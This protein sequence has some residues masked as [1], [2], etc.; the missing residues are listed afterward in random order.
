MATET[1]FTPGSGRRTWPSRVAPWGPESAAA[2]DRGNWRKKDWA[3]FGGGATTSG[4][5]TGHPRRMPFPRHVRQLMAGGNAAASDPL[6]A[7]APR[8]GTLDHARVD[9]EADPKPLGADGP[10]CGT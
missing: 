1:S 10:R 2:Q 3:P 9:A 7:D 4:G 5:A 8:K 6:G